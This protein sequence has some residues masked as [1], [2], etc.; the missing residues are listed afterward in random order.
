VEIEMRAQA[1]VAEMETRWPTFKH[2][3]PTG[4]RRAWLNVFS[5]V[6]QEIAAR[7]ITRLADDHEPIPTISQ[8]LGLVAAQIPIPRSVSFE[9]SRLLR[10][11]AHRHHD[12]EQLVLC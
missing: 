7:V 8:F 11:R 5:A 6:D 4:T 12:A 2:G 10:A 9:T 1:L 3:Q